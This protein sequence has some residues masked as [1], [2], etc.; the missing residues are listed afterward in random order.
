MG[1]CCTLKAWTLL[2]VFYSVINFIIFTVADILIL[3]GLR[4]PQSLHHSYDPTWN[5]YVDGF[6]DLDNKGP[7]VGLI[8]SRL[9]IRFLIAVSLPV[10]FIGNKSE[11]RRYLTIWEILVG[12]YIIMLI[13]DAT[14][15][16]IIENKCGL[17]GTSRSNG[18]NHNAKNISSNGFTG[19]G[20]SNNIFEPDP[21]ETSFGS[22]LDD[23]NRWSLQWARLTVFLDLVDAGIF[24]VLYILFICCVHLRGMQ[25]SYTKIEMKR[26]EQWD[27]TFTPYR[28]PRARLNSLIRDDNTL[29]LH[30]SRTATYPSINRL[31][32]PPPSNVPPYYDNY[33]FKY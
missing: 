12:I 26:F 21:N 22:D 28:I 5:E 15:F 10:L 30:S 25:I 20:D 7:L 13:A 4:S 14:Y 23:D 27:A 29:E 2:A 24:L 9:A 8:S 11:R 1:L 31:N 18:N 17:F 32:H 33:A 6:G 3:I 19:N 16:L